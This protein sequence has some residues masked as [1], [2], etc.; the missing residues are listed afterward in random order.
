MRTYH[1]KSVF[2]GIAIGKIKVWQKDPPPV[3]KHQ[4]SQ[5]ARELERFLQAKKTASDQLNELYTHACT[6][7]GGEH[8][9]IFE[10][11]QMM[12]E[13]AD[14]LE[15]ITG[16]IM[17]QEF[18]AEYAVETVC[19]QFEDMFNSMDD[20]Y[21]QARAADVRDISKRLIRILSG[22]SEDTITGQT[23]IILAAEDLSPSETMRLDKSGIIAILTTKGSVNS[24]TAILA[25]TMNIPA[26]VGIPIPLDSTIDGQEAVVDGFSG[27]AYV[28]PD[29]HMCS[30]AEKRLKEEN[31]RKQTLELL[32]G[33][34]TITKTGRQIS[35]YANVGCLDDLEFAIQNDAEGIGLFRSEFI[36]LGRNSF[37]TE[38]EQYAIYKKAA[39]IMKTKPI[40]IRTLDIG[41]DKQTD[42]FGLEKEENP[43][44]GMRAIRICLTRTEVFKTQLRAL[45]RAAV[46]GNISIMFPMI[47]SVAEMKKIKEIT[48][49]AADELRQNDIPFWIPNQGIMIET[50]AAVMISDLLAKEADFFS[51]G[52][53]DLI[54]YTLAADRQNLQLEPFIEPNSEAVM[55]MIK[56]TIENG[57]N[58]GIWVGICGEMGAD[59]D[60]TESFLRMG[61]DELSVPPASVLNV[62]KAVR[63]ISI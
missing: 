60:L 15:S 22:C 52:T 32:K 2:G 35:L 12:L 55:R 5:P 61:I 17:K 39:E 43:A 36:Y 18:N 47:T 19:S 46:H 63:E 27:T 31:E 48:A 40:I 38:D 57:H 10:I 24:H 45:F 7:V 62:R 14:Y 3:A 6:A 25:R 8:A 33:K 54:Q 28:K 34:P 4:V 9:A 59:T 50:P 29:S 37:P 1:G 11:H 58:A 41:A 53:N 16:I 13:D 30:E 20:S 42:Y 21:M 56:K 26:V 49:E 51:I 44:L 23:P